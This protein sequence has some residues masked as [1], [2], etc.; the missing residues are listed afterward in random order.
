MNLARCASKDGSLHMD[1]VVLSHIHQP[2]LRTSSCLLCCDHR[3]AY[4][5]GIYNSRA[6]N[7]GAHN[8]HP[9]VF[10][11][12]SQIRLMEALRAVCSFVSGESLLLIT[13]DSGM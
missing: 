3:T 13:C 7:E 4:E 9:L 10:I 2:H 8:D 5:R 6:L 11:R 12:R 1:L